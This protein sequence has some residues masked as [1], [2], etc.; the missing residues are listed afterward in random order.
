LFI[1][2]NRENLPDAVVPL[3]LLY[4]IAA[5]PEHHHK[6]FL[7][8]CFEDE[9][10]DAV[11]EQVLR[12]EP[13]LVAISMRNIQNNDYSGVSDNLDYYRSIID[14][15]RSVSQAGVVL[16]GSGF[17]VMPRE[18]M[19]RL[20]P[21]FGVSG[22]GELA[23]PSLLEVLENQ[24]LGMDRID[25]LYHWAG[26]KLVENPRNGSFLRLDD[27]QVPDRSLANPRYYALAGIDSIQTKR[28][29]PLRCD[30]CTYPIIEGRVGRLRSPRLVVD[31]MF[32]ALE[33][34]PGIDHF[35]FVDSVFNLPRGHALEIC[36][37]LVRRGWKTPWTCYANPLGF[38]RELAEAARAAGCEGMEIGSDSGSDRVLKQLKKGFGVEHIRGMHKLCVDA[39]IKDCHTFILGTQGECIEDV[40]ETL[41][42]AADLDPF[43]AIFMTWVDD[44]ES[45]E[46]QLREQRRGLRREIEELLRSS[47]YRRPHWS[48]P[49]LGINFSSRLFASL[50][51]IGL[52]GPLWQH[53][54]TQVLQSPVQ[55]Y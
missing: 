5:T 36:H 51:A 43:G 47:K 40:R 34:H 53:A 55:R 11:K 48:V 41:D 3:G 16:G 7:D 52:K 12:L 14:A 35:F 29:C 6:T 49:S 2:G 19:H 32:Q 27:V 39:G 33:T 50:R 54:R 31:E 25:S 10:Q 28:G 4:V 22:E 26:A 46:P 38:N 20:M 21:D 18:L 13:D 9:P 44:H 23:F 42:F 15:V 1:S 30:Y 24:G 45:I 37:E 8:L 17:S